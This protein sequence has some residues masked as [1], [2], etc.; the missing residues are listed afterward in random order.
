MKSTAI[1]ALALLAG[2]A[3]TTGK[4]REQAK[5]AG[6][7]PATSAQ[8][9]GAPGTGPSAEVAAT[10][11]GT[12]APKPTG[13]VRVYKPDGSKQCEGGGIE[14]ADMEKQLKGI[15]VLAREKANDGK[16][17]IQMCGA[18]TGQLNVYEIPAGDLAKAQKAGFKEWKL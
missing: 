3:C 2:V 10:Q 1:I 7:T 16:M 5:T 4:C 13:T 9:T 11:P 18:D 6:Q 17:R 8:D 15:K 12:Q 14:L